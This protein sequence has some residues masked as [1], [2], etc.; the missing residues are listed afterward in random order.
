MFGPDPTVAELLAPGDDGEINAPPSPTDSSE[1][2]DV[3]APQ[4]D[5]PPRHRRASSETSAAA[6]NGT[7]KTPDKMRA[8]LHH[9]PAWRRSSVELLGAIES[10]GLLD[11]ELQ[12]ILMRRKDKQAADGQEPSSSNEPSSSDSKDA[13]HTRREISLDR[14]MVRD[15]NPVVNCKR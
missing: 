8:R 14:Y 7:N 11:A 9:R 13:L 12:A 6:L 15:S 1:D 4:L 10:G 3:A 5:P 2:S